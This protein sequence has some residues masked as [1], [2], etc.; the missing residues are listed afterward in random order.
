LL[1]IRT[2]LQE[3]H[4]LERSE[5]LTKFWSENVTVLDVFEVGVG[6]GGIK[7]DL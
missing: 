5:V 4:K 3:Q 2:N 1:E 7:I 6:G